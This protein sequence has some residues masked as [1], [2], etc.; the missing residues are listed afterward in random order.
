MKTNN[1]DLGLPIVFSPLV[2]ER[3]I[4]FLHLSFL[5]DILF[6]HSYLW[7]PR[8][9]IFLIQQINSVGF[10]KECLWKIVSNIWTFQGYAIYNI[11][12]ILL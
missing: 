4:Y 7:I 11:F 1:D 12:K 9:F 6:L 2:Q 5:E 10:W 8:G 3:L